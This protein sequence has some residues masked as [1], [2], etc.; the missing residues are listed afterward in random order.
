MP[1]SDAGRR[2]IVLAIDTGSL[3][4]PAL[5]AAA[6]L[7]AGL[8]AE[9]AALFVEDERLLRLAALPFAREIGFPS[10]QLQAI[11]LEDMERA[12]RA[13]AEHLR[14]VVEETA[15]RLT[16][17]WTLAVT[18]G[19]ILSVSLARL[20]PGDLL[21]LGR[22][23]RAGFPLGGGPR[24]AGAFQALAARP[25]AVLLDE[26]DPAL[27]ALEAGHAIARVI[28]TELAVLVRAG[29]AAAF[30]TGRRQAAEWLAARGAL[31][32]YL[33]LGSGEV[34]ALAAAVRTH[35]GGALIWPGSDPAVLAAL[36]EALACPVV[37]LP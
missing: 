7:A 33:W 23:Q 1:E 37:V 8:E 14:R 10:A 9:L 13:Q 20:A 6:A 16:L 26:G 5:E 4:R 34:A 18:R 30:E 2:R 27:R 3:T 11:G 36:I 32:R 29:S 15:R 12:F 28:G 17:T 24:E 31:A 21:V 25:V 35:G 22:G 19:E